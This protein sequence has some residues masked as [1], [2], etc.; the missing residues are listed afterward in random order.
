MNENTKQ[1]LKQEIDKCKD[2]VEY[3]I[4]TYCK[5]EHPTAGVLPFELFN[6]QKS[7]LRDFRTH[8][9]NIFGKC[10]QSGIST[11]S[12]GYALWQAMFLKNR[13]I[14]ITSKRDR[15]AKDFLKKNVKFVYDNLPGWMKAIW[16]C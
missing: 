6:Y 4:E 13:K 12:G 3:F 5:I 1:K 7:C 2:S 9:L 10:R 16:H 14:L 8:R 15:D 11:L